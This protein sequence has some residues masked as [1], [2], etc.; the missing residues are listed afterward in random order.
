MGSCGAPNRRLVKHS[1]VVSSQRQ[2]VRH[3]TS[4][5]GDNE[6]AG[7]A[8]WKLARSDLMPPRQGIHG[9]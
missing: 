7:M 2:S 6:G 8:M 3:G 5:L 1:R 9:A 4:D